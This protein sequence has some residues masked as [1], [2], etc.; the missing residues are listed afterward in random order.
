[1]SCSYD[2]VG[3]RG[4][5]QKYPENSLL[6]LVEA[7]KVGARFVELD[8]QLSADG[9]PVVFHDSRLARVTSCQGDVW[10][11]SAASLAEISCHEPDRFGSE[12]EK[13]PIATLE[14]VCNALNMYEVHVFIELKKE[15][16]VRFGRKEMLDAVLRSAQSINGKYSI[17]SFDRDVLAMAKAHAPIGWVLSHYN[18]VELEQARQLAPEVLAYD[19]NKL[20][21]EQPLW[22]GGWDW[23]LY[24]IVDPQQAGLWCD[25]GVRYIETWDIERLLA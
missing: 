7:A 13:T 2:A 18:E 6:G 4:F 20:N 3:H 24:D 9:V 25:L 23:F 19:V 21:P 15:S 17:I 14:Q 8:V 22:R 12:F 11:Y 16:L 1:M 5:P 10:D